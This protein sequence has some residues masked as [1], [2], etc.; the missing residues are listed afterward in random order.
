[1]NRKLFFVLSSFIFLALAGCQGTPTASSGVPRFEKGDCPFTEPQG[2]TVQCGSLVVPEDR[3]AATPQGGA[4]A[5]PNAKTI[6][7]QVA[8]FKSPSATPAPDPIIYLEGGP[9]SSTLR[10]LLDQFDIYFTPFLAQRDLILFD[11]RGTGYSQPALDCPELTQLALDTL[12]Q[13]L[14]PAESE[15]LSD[16]AFAA[17]H[18][19]L[20]TQGV[21]LAAYNSAESAADLADLRSA[22]GLT[23]W[24]LYGTSYGTRLALTEMRDH[25]QGLRSVVIDSVVPLQVDTFAGDYANTS[26]AIN[27]LFDAC[28][29]DSAC[30]TAFPNLKQTYADTVQKLNDKPVPVKITLPDMGIPGKAGTQADALLT[31]DTLT[32]TVIQALYDT[33]AL[34]FLPEIISLTAKGDYG[35]LAD[36]TSRLLT[37]YKQISYGMNAS[38]Q[39]TEEEPFTSPAVMATAEASYPEVSR[40]LGTA[41]GPFALCKAW[42]V[43]AAGAVENQPVTSS[44]PTLVLSGQ[45]DPVTPPAWGKLAA[46]SLS[47]SYYFEVPAA[48]HGSSLTEACPRRLVLAFLD[49]PGAAPDASCLKDMKLSFD[50]P[51]A[52]VQVELAPFTNSQSAIS[53]QAPANWRTVGG[54]Q[55]FYSPTGQAT[56]PTQ[57]LIEAL[58]TSAEQFLQMMN[59]NL[60]NQGV[61][62]S[63]TGE[64]KATPNLTFTLY[65]ASGGLSK[66][67]MALAAS[68]GNCYVVLLQSSLGEHDALY[69]AVFL[70]VMNSLKPGQ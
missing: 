11:Q 41:N 26:K 35:P 21:N 25:P 23:S 5:N 28:A 67:D 61:T 15:R 13:D 12:N 64:T 24:N 2:Q 10:G 65:T 40:V 59:N 22:L 62:L 17:C 4:G 30:S 69:Q 14:K 53:G 49:T 7:L 36:L 31:G 3:S 45:F 29:A 46:A 42:N 19:R 51:A 63:P 58:P 39:C 43:P 52:S 6:R 37:V 9:G 1:M 70:P 27:A 33:T 47:K 68:G 50:V 57:L 38:V 48:A 60:A 18:D 56:D 8:I 44:V 32:S 16:Q 20:L 55:G 66:I 34:G 54:L